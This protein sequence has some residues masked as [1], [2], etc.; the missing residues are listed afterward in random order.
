MERNKKRNLSND[1]ENAIKS[2]SNDY[3]IVIKEADKGGAVVIMDADYYKSKVME[4]LSNREFYNEI[5]EKQGKKIIQKVKH[6]LKKHKS[7]SSLT[8]KETEFLTDFDFIES[9]FYGLPKVHKSKSIREA[10]DA[11]ISDYITCL[12]PE[13]LTF[14]PIV[15]GPIS[16]TQ[17]LSQL[18]DILLKPLCTEVKSYVRDDLDFLRHLPDKILPSETLV[19]MDVTNLYTN[20]IS[21][22]GLKAL[23]YWIDKH[24]EKINYRFTKDFILEA[25]EIVLKNNTFSFCD[26]HYEQIKGTA[27][28]TKMAPT[29]ATLTLGYLEEIL[30]EKIS[31]RFDSTTAINIKQKWKRY[32][33]DC[34]IIWNV[35]NMNLD[36]F[37][38]I[39]N[40]LD[41]DI[42]FTVEENLESIS[43][44]DVLI[45]RNGEKL[46]TDVYY[47]TTD[48]HQYLHFG[49]CHPRH[50]KRS[51]P[52]NLSRRICTIVSDEERRKE[53]LKE[54]K[55]YLL[56]QKYPLEIIEDGIKKAEELDR[57][58]L[59]NP[60]STDTTEEKILPFV[61]TH[62]PRNRNMTPFVQHLNGV[63]KTDEKMSKVLQNFQFINSKRQPKNLRRLLCKSH[64]QQN[65]VHSVSKCPDRRCGTCPYIREGN[66]FKIGP[67]DFKVN[68]NMSCD[69]KNV[70]YCIT[71]EGCGQ[72]YIGETGTTLRTRIRIHKQ[73][74]QHPEYRQ[75]KVSEHLDQCGN[76]HFTVFPFY[77]LLTDSTVERREKEKHF[78]KSLKPTL[79]SLA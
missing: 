43:F 59:I 69:S 4:M 53:R 55:G 66:T 30:Y 76:G 44:L 68:A 5:P 58:Q 37:Y 20:I 54:L 48:T 31:D 46:T 1:E 60:P 15:G 41:P 13:D 74:I 21:T 39:L 72:F 33:D 25:T 36:I 7:T 27:M 6:L 52:Y 11:Q 16:P 51:I 65:N 2:L 19:T 34:F 17:H 12:K 49:S 45:T 35:N 63:L 62:S 70:I 75:V 50:T 22:L 26:K 8:K 79:N 71:C 64:F 61:T 23:K 18:L 9:V 67:K 57:N 38:D 47:K 24:P 78:I 28:G 10:I 29:Y 40:E 32:L 56:D 14:I 3:S 42:H 77:K 73:H